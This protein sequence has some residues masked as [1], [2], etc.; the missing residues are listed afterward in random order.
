MFPIYSCKPELVGYKD[1]FGRTFHNVKDYL[2]SNYIKPHGSVNWFLGRRTT[3]RVL[4]LERKFEFDTLVRI[5]TAVENMYKSDS[6]EF[7][8]HRIIEPDDRNLYKIDNILRE[9]EDQYFYPLIFLP[10]IIKNYDF[11]SG[12]SSEI[13][14]RAKQFFQQATEIYLIGYG[15]KDDI[16]LDLLKEIQQPKVKLH[17]ANTTNSSATLM[18]SLLNKFSLLEQGSINDKGFSNFVSEY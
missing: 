10:L 17:I 7:A 15:A 3:D 5:V 9:F 18:K 16:I 12:F 8:S 13:I 14:Q 2:D 6:I 1:V 11:V 4:N